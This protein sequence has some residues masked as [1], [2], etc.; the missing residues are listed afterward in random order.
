MRTQKKDQPQRQGG[1]KRIRL[2]EDLI[3]GVHPVLEALTEEAERLSEV[4]LQKERRG[5]R[6]EEIIELAR[7]KG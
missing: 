2:S 6:F 5:A 4:I 1:E 7:Q 3:W